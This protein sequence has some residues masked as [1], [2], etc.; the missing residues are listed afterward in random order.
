MPLY[1][2]DCYLPQPPR[3]WSRVEN[4]CSTVNDAMFNKGNVLQYRANAYTM[5]KS[6]KYSK[7]AK[8]Q[9]IH[10]TWATQSPKGYTNPNTQGLKRAGNVVNMA[11]NPQTNTIIGPTLLPITCPDNIS[12]PIVIQN[13]GF[14]ICSIQENICTGEIKVSNSQQLCHPASASNVPGQTYLCWNDGTQ[15]WTPRQRTV[16][17]NSA[18]KWPD[19]AILF[20]SVK[21]FPPIITSLIL[22]TETVVSLTWVQSVQCLPVSVFNIFQNGILIRVV[23]STIFTADFIVSNCNTY[24]YYIIGVTNGSTI[25][26]EPSNTV[27]IT[28]KNIGPPTNLNYITL[29][30]NTIKLMWTPN[31]NCAPTVSYNIYKD[32]IFIGNTVDTFFIV[33]SLENCIS[34]SFSVSSIDINDIESNY[35]TINAIPLWVNPPTNL[36]TSYNK[37]N[38]IIYWSEPNPNCSKPTS[39][40][41]YWSTNNN[42]FNTITNILPNQTSYSFANALSNTIYYFYMVSINNTEIS[43]PTETISQSTYI[44]TITGDQNYTEEIVGNNY[45]LTFYTNTNSNGNYNLSFYVNLDNVIF[46]LIGAGGG[47]RGSAYHSTSSSSLELLVGGVGGG[48]GSSLKCSS[49]FVASYE[50]KNTLSLVVGKGGLGGSTAK[51][52]LT[53][54]PGN[55]TSVYGITGTVFY[56][57]AFG[58]KT[59]TAIGVD[60]TTTSLGNIYYAI[61]APTAESPDTIGAYINTTIGGAS[62]NGSGII[63]DSGRGQSNSHS[64]GGNGYNA[65]NSSGNLPFG[66]GGGTN[67]MS[68]QTGDTFTGSVVTLNDIGGLQGTRI[69]NILNNT[70]LNGNQSQSEYG[71]TQQPGLA[72]GGGGGGLY[73]RFNGSDV[74]GVG[75]NGGDGLLIV[76]FTYI[77]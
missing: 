64:E 37:P 31:E 48:G 17:S 40:I 67:V 74:F 22:T 20:S 38:I 59:S 7:I 1:N 72:S 5:T 62:R 54:E 43:L 46:T 15:T 2:S 51:G 9:W 60:T 68:N 4:N 10:K 27:S 70:Y 69:D 52:P 26:S 75:G 77:N 23:P 47:G 42:T 57:I 71:T 14:L 58:G 45:T 73:W 66:G 25:A 41:L 28:I 36:Y 3:A 16:M 76:S 65:I 56:A 11:I 29:D 18:N 6:Q 30:T 39:Y 24:S 53:A 50:N 13:G 49:G 34:Y 21:P 44:Y 33:N 63:Y 12:N 8:G 61:G 19:N 55:N 35:S 32:T